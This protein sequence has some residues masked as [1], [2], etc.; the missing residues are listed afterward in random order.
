M[1]QLTRLGLEFTKDLFV[2]FDEIR[3][4]GQVVV[5]RYATWLLVAGALG[6]SVGYQAGKRVERLSRLVGR[7]AR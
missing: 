5:D 2:D 7:L 1:S 6:M 3:L 4:R